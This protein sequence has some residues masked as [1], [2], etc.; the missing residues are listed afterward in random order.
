M[1]MAES[2]E[3][4]Q[5]AQENK[6]WEYANSSEDNVELDGRELSEEELSEVSGGLSWRSVKNFLKGG[7]GRDLGANRAQM[8][9]NWSGR[10]R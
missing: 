8:A 2:N 10:N 5:I 1:N 6:F 9:E 4:K 7:W 3:N